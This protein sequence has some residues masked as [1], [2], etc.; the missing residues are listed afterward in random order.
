MKYVQENKD[1]FQKIDQDTYYAIRAFLHSESKLKK[2]LT[3][4]ENRGEERIDMCK[5][6]DDLYNSGVEQGHTLGQKEGRV[7]GHN[8]EK[9]EVASRL[10]GILELEKIAEVVGL[11][12]EIV[13]G[14]ERTY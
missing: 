8:Q 3:K 7:Q 5:A 10:Q 6:L 11:E 4:V 2:A 9:R 13:R 14:L 12:L 1:F